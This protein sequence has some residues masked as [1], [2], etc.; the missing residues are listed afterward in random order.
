VLSLRCKLSDFYPAVITSV[1]APSSVKRN[2]R[3][4]IGGY[5]RVRI[6]APE[7]T[8]VLGSPGSGLQEVISFLSS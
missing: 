2:R 6:S 1:L 8:P 7:K 3:Q 5:H 4:K